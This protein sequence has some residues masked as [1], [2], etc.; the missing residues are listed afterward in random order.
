MAR[1]SHKTRTPGIMGY[2]APPVCLC[3]AALASATQWGAVPPVSADGVLYM[4]AGRSLRQGSGY[5][6]LDGKPETVMPPGYPVLIGATERAL[7]AAYGRSARGAGI[8][9]RPP[10]PETTELAARAVS[11][12]T[13]SLSVLLLYGLLSRLAAPRT[14]LWA[15]AAFCLLP[16]R[17]ELSVQVL[18]EST[19]L[20]LVMVGAILWVA[21]VGGRRSLWQAATAGLAMGAAYLVRPEGLLAGVILAVGLAWQV[22]HSGRSGLWRAAAF[23][24][25]MLFCVAPYVLWLHARTGEWAVSGKALQTRVIATSSARDEGIRPVLAPTLSPD[26]RTVEGLEHY[27]KSATRAQM[28][29]MYRRNGLVLLGRLFTTF[30]LLVLLLPTGARALHEALGDR[31]GAAGWLALALLSPIPALVLF[32]MEARYLVVFAPVVCTVAAAAVDSGRTA[33]ALHLAALAVLTVALCI[34]LHRPEKAAFARARPDRQV[35]A[36]IRERQD[37]DAAVVAGSPQYAFYAGA[38]PLSLPD[39]PAERVARYARHNG[40]CW[41]VVPTHDTDY[42]SRLIR[43]LTADPLPRGVKLVHTVPTGNGLEVRLYHIDPAPARSGASE[44][45]AP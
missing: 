3:L 24:G 37:T 43:S 22:R 4:A 17:A 20:L 14:A 19:Y 36:F 1:T 27:S 2:L 34:P 32:R 11:L 21:G 7:L 44:G 18:S 45:A 40:A 42:H 15:T 29:R 41:L 23:T 10:S 12:V 16:V 30:G 5:R 9:A 6:S 25:A 33:K 38:R 8:P 31:R 35:G 26:C 13:S 39:E 28:L